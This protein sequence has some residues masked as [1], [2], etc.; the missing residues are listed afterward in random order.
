MESSL[1]FTRRMAA[2]MA[3]SSCESGCGGDPGPCWGKSLAASWLLFPPGCGC[4][5]LRVS[6]TTS[7]RIRALVG[8]APLQRSHLGFARLRMLAHIWHATLSSARNCATASAVSCCPKFEREICCMSPLSSCPCDAF[9]A[10]PHCAHLRM[11]ETLGWLSRRPRRR[12]T[13]VCPVAFGGSCRL[14][15]WAARSARAESLAARH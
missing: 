5:P 4:C 6:G 1:R 7:P 2:R 3:S 12:P 8:V 9:A 14:R 15:A 11:L 13:P 10:S